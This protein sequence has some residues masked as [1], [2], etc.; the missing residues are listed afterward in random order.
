MRDEERTEGKNM[1]THALEIFH[2]EFAHPSGDELRTRRRGGG[3][4]HSEELVELS[5]IQVVWNQ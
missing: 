2:L 5:K 3:H 1:K 4:G